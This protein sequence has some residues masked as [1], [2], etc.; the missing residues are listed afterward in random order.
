[1]LAT[2]VNCQIALRKEE[3]ATT[4]CPSPHRHRLVHFVNNHRNCFD[5]RRFAAFW[6]FTNAF[7]TYPNFARVSTAQADTRC[8]QRSGHAMSPAKPPSCDLSRSG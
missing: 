3:P 8:R 5:S 2:R 7:V 6:T 1:V 4:R